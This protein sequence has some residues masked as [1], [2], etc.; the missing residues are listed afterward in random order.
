M[1]MARV[2][3][4]FLKDFKGEKG[5]SEETAEAVSQHLRE[6]T[7]VDVGF[8]VIGDE[9]PDVGPYKENAGDSFFGLSEPGLRTSK[10]MKLAGISDEGRTRVVNTALE[11]M[12]RHL[13]EIH[14]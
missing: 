5:V 11:V 14:N 7:G 10:H 1:S 3:K 9:S 2:G 4:E 8:S 6:K 12:R 13:M